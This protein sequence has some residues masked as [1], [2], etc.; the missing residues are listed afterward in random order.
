MCLDPFRPGWVSRCLAD[1]PAGALFH[2][3]DG[4]TKQNL[5]IAAHAVSGEIASGRTHEI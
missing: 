1:H 5:P 2:T 4:W 3:P